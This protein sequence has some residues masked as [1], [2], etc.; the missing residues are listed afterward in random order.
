MRRAQAAFEQAGF[1]VT[2]AP[3]SFMA[4]PPEFSWLQLTPTLDAVESSWLA[5]REIIGQIWYVLSPRF[6]GSAT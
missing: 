4:G 3:H 5:V 1:T 6:T 2:P